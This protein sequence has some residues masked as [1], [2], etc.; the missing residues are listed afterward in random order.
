MRAHD[1]FSAHHGPLQALIRDVRDLIVQAPQDC[2]GQIERL[3]AWCTATGQYLD[4][5]YWHSALDVERA[6][7]RARAADLT[8][9]QAAADAKA[10]G[11]AHGK[12]VA[13]TGETTS[14]HRRRYPH[15]GL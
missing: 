13:E 1:T 14:T 12:A 4:K 7:E 10:H 3:E 2:H 11:E 8:A 5:G 15:P 9:R 6:Q